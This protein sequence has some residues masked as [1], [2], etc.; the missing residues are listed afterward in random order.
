MFG[1]RL[2][3]GEVVK[4]YGVP[5]GHRMSPAFLLALTVCALIHIDAEYEMG[6]GNSQHVERVS[7]V[8]SNQTFGCTGDL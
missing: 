1:Y 7:R 8:W 6:K 3:L 2:L 4:T 5:Y